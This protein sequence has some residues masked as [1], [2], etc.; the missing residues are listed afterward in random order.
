MELKIVLPI[1]GFENIKN[2]KL[3]KIDDFFYE[4]DCGEITFTLIDPTNLREY[5][6]TISNSYKEALSI[7]KQD[8][9]KIYNLVIISNPIENS[10]IN[11]LAPILVNEKKEILGQIA[12]DENRYKEYGLREPIKNFL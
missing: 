5:D 9:V 3:K 11:F 4:L 10:T 8:D 2:V 7:E 12:L 6:F 1:F